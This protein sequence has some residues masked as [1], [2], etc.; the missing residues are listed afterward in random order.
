MFCP[1]SNGNLLFNNSWKV[2]NYN[3]N[4]NLLTNNKEYLFWGNYIDT[5]DE[6]TLVLP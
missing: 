5:K 1:L 6:N 2:T 4:K 3:Y